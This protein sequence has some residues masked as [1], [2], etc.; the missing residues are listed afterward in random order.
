MIEKKII[1]KEQITHFLLLI[2]NISG[3]EISN[4]ID[5]DEAFKRRL[6]FQKKTDWKRFRAS[7]DLL[8]DTE[9]GIISAFTYQLGNLENKNNDF[10]EIN[11]RLYGI[12][13][14]VYLQM[15]AFE[16]ISILLNHSSRA[17]I[18][19]KFHKLDIYKLRGIAGAHT[20]DYLYD[21]ETLAK[22]P[23]IFKNTSFRIVQSYLEKTGNKIVVIDENDLWS[24]YNLISLLIE[25]EKIATEL[26]IEIIRFAI[27]K[28]I[29]KKE[30]KIEIEQELSKLIPN[31]IDYTTLDKNKN[32][33]KRESEKL[34]KALNKYYKKEKKT[35]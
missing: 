19:K 9:Y 3:N 13:N 21:K 25:Y 30:Q 31:L 17:E 29:L 10:G 8:D 12:L 33:R 7:V 20:V 22:N 34:D 2:L 11:L 14:A 4:S 5:I 23:K 28:L 16:E 26:L 6:K 27:N 18:R 1:Q 24:E 35:P 15:N 32:Y